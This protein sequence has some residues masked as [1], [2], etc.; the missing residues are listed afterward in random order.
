MAQ[1]KTLNAMHLSKASTSASWSLI[2]LLLP[3]FGIILAVNSLGH[4]SKFDWNDDEEKAEARSVRRRAIGGMTISVLLFSIGIIIVLVII[5]AI[6]DVPSA[7]SRSLDTT[8]S[9]EQSHVISAPAKVGGTVNLA[10]P[11]GLAVTLV[12]VTDPAHSD[13]Q[14]FTADAGKHFVALNFKIVNNGSSSYR[15]DANSNATVIGSD[16]QTYTAS[17]YSVSGCTNFSSGEYALASGE[18]ATGCVVFQIPDGIN[19]A[20]VQFQGNSDVNDDTAEW[21]TQ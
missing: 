16:N 4:L 2:G 11:K 8:T 10:G 6:R 9:T 7:V 1:N 18:S 14:Y 20:K 17:F 3:L 15:D 19:I 13:N 21:M 5:T 12:Q